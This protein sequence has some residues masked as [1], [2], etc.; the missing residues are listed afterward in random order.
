MRLK[1]VMFLGIYF[2]MQYPV[3]LGLGSNRATLHDEK[4]LAPHQIL[5]KACRKLSV[6]M[7][8][9]R[10]SSVY[11]TAPMYVE[12]Q[13]DFYN[14]AVYG[15]FDGTP[16]FLLQCTQDIEA[17][18]GRNRLNEV[19]NGPRSL[20][21]DIE[22]FADRSIESSIL[23]IP[24]PRLS[25]RAFILIP[26]LEILPEYAEVKLRDFYIS[27]LKKIKSD[28]VVKFCDPFLMQQR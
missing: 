1:K 9:M 27:C 20:D 11:R 15:L 17:H 12:D 2:N 7:H 5:E 3:V 23:H 24:H 6:F 28:D 16:E 25:E 8:A 18:F 26:M 21:I 13:D 10:M 19:R 22:L 4:K 14:M